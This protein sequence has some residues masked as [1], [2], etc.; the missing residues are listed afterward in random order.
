MVRRKWFLGE[1]VV[2]LKR[3]GWTVLAR[4]NLLESFGIAKVIQPPNRA[5]AT[6][7]LNQFNP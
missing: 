3:C 4:R 1:L 5:L 2:R 6:A 7:S